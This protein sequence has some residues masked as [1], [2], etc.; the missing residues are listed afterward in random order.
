MSLA[1][2]GYSI[3]E[4]GLLS[5]R[6][7]SFHLLD[8]NRIGFSSFPVFSLILHHLDIKNWHDGKCLSLFLGSGV[9][10]SSFLVPGVLGSSE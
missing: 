7:I 3:V 8:L 1:C 10:G 9:L 5:G 6:F 2:V 4:K